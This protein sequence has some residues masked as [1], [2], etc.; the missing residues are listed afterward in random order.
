MKRVILTG[1]TGAIGMALI[2]TFLKEDIE[3]AAVCH[4]GSKRISQIPV[5]EKVKLVECDLKEIQTLPMMLDGNYDVFYH[6][7]WSGTAG[8]A[9]DLVDMQMKNIQYT[10]DA[11]EA[12]CKTGCRK[13]IGAGSQAEYGRYEGKLNADVPAFPKNG[14][15]IAKLCAGQLSRL[16]CSQL[17]MEHVWARILSVYGPYDGEQTMVMSLLGH[18]L[19]GKKPSCTKGEQVWDYLYSK[20]AARALYLLGKN[21]KSQKTYCI[22]S[23]RSR[24]LVQYMEILRD[25]V[26]PQCELGLGDIPYEQK[27]VMYLCADISE[28]KKDTGFEPAY[29]FEKGIEET[30]QWIREARNTALRK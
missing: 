11:V 24:P 28:L 9:R 10:V 3:V 30:I 20:D 21:G 4:R 5:V 19:S 15:G 27:Q 22:G 6:L 25:A 29:T 7:A 8:D 14:Y 23:G 16:R 26:C 12:A 13:F 18:L 2:Q 1:P 17:G